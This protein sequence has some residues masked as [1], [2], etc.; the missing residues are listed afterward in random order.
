[1][2]G[3]ALKEFSPRGELIGAPTPPSP[4]GKHYLHLWGTKWTLAWNGAFCDFFF[5]F[6]WRHWL[7]LQIISC[8]ENQ[9]FLF[10]KN[11]INLP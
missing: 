5:S 10:N 9:L 7:C 3:H 8:T 2:I 1:M 11:V 6:V 4:S